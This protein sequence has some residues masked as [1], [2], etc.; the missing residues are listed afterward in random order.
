MGDVCKEIV[1]LLDSLSVGAAPGPVFCEICGTTVEHAN[2]AFFYQGKKWEFR[3]P[4]CRK[5]NPT[6]CAHAA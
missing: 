6:N 4:L 2:Y 3:L 5:C 1:K